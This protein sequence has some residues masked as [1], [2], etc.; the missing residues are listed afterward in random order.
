MSLSFTSPLQ[1]W[2]RLLNIIPEVPAIHKHIFSY[3]HFTGA[4]QKNTVFVSTRLLDADAHLILK[5]CTKASPC[6]ITDGSCG[7]RHPCHWETL[8]K[9][10]RLLIPEGVSNGLGRCLRS[11][12]QLDTP[13]NERWIGRDL[14]INK[15]RK[16]NKPDRFVPR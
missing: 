5:R 8:G 15:R 14:D 7:S 13:H 4:N 9:S 10:E 6:P 3:C 12:V 16:T 2:Q 1:I 11:M